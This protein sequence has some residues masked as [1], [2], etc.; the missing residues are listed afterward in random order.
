MVYIPI[1]NILSTVSSPQRQNS[2]VNYLNKLLLLWCT[3]QYKAQFQ[4]PKTVAEKLS[5]KLRI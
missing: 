3:Y 5:F 2:L 4:V 1:Q